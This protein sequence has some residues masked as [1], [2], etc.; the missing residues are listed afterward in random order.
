MVNETET[1][2]NHEV[3]VLHTVKWKHL[4]V[5]GAQSTA[6]AEIFYLNIRNSFRY[7]TCT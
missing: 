3:Y 1:L 4:H 6:Q 7:K 5:I 2:K